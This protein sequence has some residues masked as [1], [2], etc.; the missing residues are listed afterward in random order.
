MSD[1]LAWIARALGAKEAR[2]GERIQSLWSGYGDLFRVHTPGAA[3]PTAIVKW[4]RPPSG[5]SG[6]RGDARK[7]RSYE[8]E[9]AFYRAFASRCDATCRVPR[10]LGSR[11]L[12]GERILLLEDLD[13]AGFRGRR[14]EVRGDEMGLC[15]AWLASFHARFLGDAPEELWPEGTY[16]HLGTRPEEIEA[17]DDDVLREAA[18]LLDER[19]QGAR[20][21]TLVHGDAKEANFCFGQGSVAAVDFQYVGGGTGMR[22]VAYLLGGRSVGEAAEA[23]ELDVY[24]AHLRRALAL[25]RPEVDAAEVE[26]EWRALYPVAYADFC[27]FLAGWAKAHWRSDT[28]G[29]R[30]AHAI[31]RSLL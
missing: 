11:V 17:M 1:E 25:R 4:V 19:L 8:V 22:D 20:F 9:T 31:A 3:A 24:F 13:A 6:S 27:R 7:L 26:A 16:W 2:R 15:L 21:R 18:P 5:R 12:E 30:R 23:R 29:Q 28:E 14:H 10:L